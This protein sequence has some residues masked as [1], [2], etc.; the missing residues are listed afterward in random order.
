MRAYF[1]PMAATLLLAGPAA[2][3]SLLGERL[4]NVTAFIPPQCYTKTTDAAGRA[5]NP[6]FTCHVASRRPNAINDGDLQ[7]SYAFPGPAL[8]N[9]WSNLFEDRRPRIAEISDA[10]I[11]ACI[12]QDNYLVPDG[13]IAL[14]AR[15]DDLPSS[16]DVDGDGRWS[17]Y[18]PDVHFRF[19]AEGYD[20]APDG[21]RSG[22]RAF[23]YTL[24]PG[25]FSPASGSTDDVLIR[26]PAAYREDEAGKPDWTAY[27]VNL[28]I[29]ESLIRRADVAIAPID[30]ARFGVDLDKDGRLAGADHIAF[31]WAPLEGQD[32]SYVGRAK[33]LQEAGEAPLAA[34]LYPLGSEFVHSVRYVDPDDGDEAG[35]V[36]LSARLKELRYMQKTVWQSYADLEESALTEIKEADDFP[37]RLPIFDGNAETGIANGVGWRLQAY[38][39]DRD[40]AL[41]PQSFEETVFCVGCHGGV[42]VTDDS[43]FAFARKLAAPD[44]GWF[45]WSQRGLADVADPLGLGGVGEYARY[46]TENGAGDEFRAN[47]EIIEAFFMPDGAPKQDALQRLAGDVSTLLYPSRRRAL[48]LNKAYRTIVLDQDFIHGRSAQI[49][50]V[51]NVHREVDDEQPTGIETPL[52]RW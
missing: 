25:S 37:D 1:F 16:W 5:H 45:H 29:V 31:A 32:M 52:R 39:E 12:R 33:R 11:L 3:G 23:A 8:V 49:A 42:G 19:D 7:T 43:T 44:G 6:C 22:W 30:E 2:A 24:L 41:R 34:G 35:G 14:T 40:G 28:A 26:L 27:A 47:T 4:E 15:L 46:L 9:P 48:D 13:G 21:T 50:P 18:R 20:L 10:D 36:R 38:I 17:G 51:E